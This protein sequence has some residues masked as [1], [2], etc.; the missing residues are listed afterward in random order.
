MEI[1]ESEESFGL[2]EVVGVWCDGWCDVRIKAS[3]EFLGE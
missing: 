2:D 3:C 1:E